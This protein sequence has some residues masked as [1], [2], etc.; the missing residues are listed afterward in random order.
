MLF[1]WVFPAKMSGIVLVTSR[2][3]SST[4]VPGLLFN[5]STYVLE[6]FQNDSITLN[7]TYSKTIGSKYVPEQMGCDS[8]SK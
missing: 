2:I 1:S 3:S 6:H 4:N 7:G 8:S 5:H